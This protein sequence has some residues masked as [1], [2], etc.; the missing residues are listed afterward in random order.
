VNL[1]ARMPITWWGA[2]NTYLQF[3]IFN[4]TNTRQPDRVSSVTNATPLVVNG[5]P[6]A[7]KAFFYTY[8]SPRTLSV[9]LHAQ[10]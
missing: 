3:N 2:Q 10:F 4:L 7:A 8:N 6:V 1:D 5:N 9:T